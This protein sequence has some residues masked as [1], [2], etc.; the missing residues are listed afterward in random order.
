MSF[1]SIIVPIYNSEN[2]L[3]RCV[4]SILKQRHTNFELLLIND[5]STDSSGAICDKYAKLDF[6]V[7]VFHQENRGVSSA[8][9]LGLDNARGEWITFVDSDD[10]V[11]DGYLV[12]L[13]SN[14]KK[15]KSVDLVISYAEYVYNDGHRRE[16]RYQSRVVSNS[17]DILFSENDLNWHTSPWAKLY[18]SEICKYIRF[19]IGLQIGEDLVFLYTYILSCQKIIVLSNTD[20]VYYVNNQTSLTKQIHNYE[21]EMFAYNNVN[22]VVNKL[23]A[24]KGIMDKTAIEKLQ[25]IIAYFV[26]RVLNS[27]YYGGC[28][29]SYNERMSKIKLQNIDSYV[30]YIEVNSVKEWCYVS[31]LK[32]R[33]FWIYDIIRVKIANIK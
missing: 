19:I 9:N 4:D 12:N 22:C 27:I 24:E 31:L 5:G 8:R 33:L 15:D 2:C 10:Y 25:W 7:R 29:Y 26:R 17:I 14:V 32:L 23:I 6:R 13:I 30:K 21:D 16:E 18:K 28:K 3:Q 20:Y 11:K 1:V